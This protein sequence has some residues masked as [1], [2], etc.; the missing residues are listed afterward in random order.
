MTGALKGSDSR[1]TVPRP[2]W[3]SYWRSPPCCRATAVGAV[4]DPMVQQP[5]Q[6]LPHLRHRPPLHLPAQG[7]K[8]SLENQER[9]GHGAQRGVMVNASPHSAL[10]VI[11]PKLALHVLVVALH[12]PAQ[13]AQAH[14]GLERGVG[15]QRA[16]PVLC[17]LLLPL[18]PLDKQP[19]LFSRGTTLNMLA[20]TAD[21][22]T[23]EARALRPLAALAPLHRAVAQPQGDL[24]G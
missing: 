7:E 1:A 21:A 19:F 14:Q 20:G 18:R 9:A 16:E 8:R 23:G 4:P 5:L 17:G 2:G 3:L 13:L 24:L 11:E 12:P 6:R 22:H 10:E 15:R